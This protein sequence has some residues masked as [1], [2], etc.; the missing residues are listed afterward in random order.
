MMPGLFCADQAMGYF[1]SRLSPFEFN[2]TALSALAGR[3]NV[4]AD[5]DKNDD[6]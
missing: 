2:I 4:C 6:P 1:T 5:W 3:N